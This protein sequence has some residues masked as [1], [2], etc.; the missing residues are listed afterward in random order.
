MAMGIWRGVSNVARTV[1]KEWRGVSNVARN[2]KAEWRG[3]SN[4]ARQVFRSGLISS[5]STNNSNAYMVDLGSMGVSFRYT[6]TD[7]GYFYFYGDFG[8]KTMSF[9]GV[10]YDTSSSIGLLDSNGNSLWSHGFEESYTGYTNLKV[11]A[12][13]TCIRIIVATTGGS[14]SETLLINKLLV[15]D[16]DLLEEIR[17]F[18]N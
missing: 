18:I 6:R 15:D 17:G 1:K 12:E 13:V 9:S 4:V 14:A 8:G 5:Y 7:Y 2:I 11:P 3:V 10:E 16:Y